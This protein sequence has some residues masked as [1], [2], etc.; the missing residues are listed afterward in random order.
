MNNRETE[1]LVNVPKDKHPCQIKREKWNLYVQPESSV[2]E[3][4]IDVCNLIVSKG[5]N[6][7]RANE[8]LYQADKVLH[9]M[10]LEAEFKSED[11]MDKWFERQNGH[12][13]R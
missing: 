10:A 2:E 13:G 3:D 4:V 9:E 1:Q 7:K 12:K 5:M 11:K 8:V 6:Y